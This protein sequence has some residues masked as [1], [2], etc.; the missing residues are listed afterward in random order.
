MEKEIAGNIFKKMLYN[1]KWEKI[2]N[3]LNEK[4]SVSLIYPRDGGGRAGV[5]YFC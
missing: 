2:E 1:K 4:N 3:K 5:K